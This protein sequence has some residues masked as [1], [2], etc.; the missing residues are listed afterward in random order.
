MRRVYLALDLAEAFIVNSVLEAHGINAVVGDDLPVADRD[1]ASV[2]IAEDTLYEQARNV[3]MAFSLG[4][5]STQDSWHCST[6][7]EQIEP[8][9]TECWKCGTNRSGSL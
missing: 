7:Q 8:Q 6:C 3:V 4:E 5:G 2:W 9:F 1:W